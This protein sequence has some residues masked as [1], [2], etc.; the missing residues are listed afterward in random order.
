MCSFGAESDTQMLWVQ[1]RGRGRAVDVRDLDEAS[2][3]LTG[4][5][6]VR[7]L[8]KKALAVG[9]QTYIDPVTGFSVFTEVREWEHG[10]VCTTAEGNPYGTAA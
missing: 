3:R 10:R 1:R 4:R 7:A 9:A 6:L 8:H 2:A 5:Q